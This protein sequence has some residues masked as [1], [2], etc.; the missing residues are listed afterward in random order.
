MGPSSPVQ[1]YSSRPAS[2]LQE[3][4]PSQLQRMQEESMFM[5]SICFKEFEE[6]EFYPGVN[7]NEQRSARRGSA[8]SSCS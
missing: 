3:L 4:I 1:Y 2:F 7:V 8:E 5:R 6:V